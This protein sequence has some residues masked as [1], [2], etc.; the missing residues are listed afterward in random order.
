MPGLVQKPRAERTVE[1]QQEIEEEDAAAAA[2]LYC[3]CQQA[4]DPG[5]P[6]DW[7][8]C[9]K[10]EQWFHPEC[11]GTTAQ[12]CSLCCQLCLWL[13]LQTRRHAEG[14]WVCV[15]LTNEFVQHAW[16]LIHTASAHMLM[17]AF[18]RAC[19]ASTPVFN[20]GRAWP[21][22]DAGGGEHGGVGVPAVHATPQRPA[23]CCSA[24]C[25]HQV[26]L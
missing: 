2:E 5:A 22:S 6:R 7:V 8:Q 13:L 10:C 4:D 3:L 18:R 14:V 17:E 26:C 1:E 20:T 16:A 24:R 9:D 19:H 21:A 12:V 25:A 23:H 15:L 11:V